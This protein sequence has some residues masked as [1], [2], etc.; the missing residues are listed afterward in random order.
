MQT[1]HG[2]YVVL[3][4]DDGYRDFYTEAFPILR[5]IS[6]TIFLPHPVHPSGP[7]IPFK[8]ESVD[9]WRRELRRGHSVGSH[10]VSHVQMKS[11]PK[12]HAL[13]IRESKKHRGQPGRR[14]ESLHPYAFPD[15]DRGLVAY[16][17]EEL[18]PAATGTASV[19]G[20][21]RRRNGTTGT[22]SEGAD[23]GSDDMPLFKAK[24]SEYD[25]LNKIQY[26]STD[27][28]GRIV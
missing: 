21:A 18:N 3:T 25:W 22:S 2:K 8:E 5:R 26:L 27:K 9:W 11:L 1:Q 20:S 4:F 15:E 12:G 24:P 10:T 14:R 7:N 6:A 28:K 23:G 16:I 13:E 19:R 17:R